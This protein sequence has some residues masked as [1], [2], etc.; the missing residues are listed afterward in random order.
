MIIKSDNTETD[1]LLKHFGIE[2]IN[3]YIANVL[4]VKST[5]INSN[6]KK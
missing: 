5:S 6:N 4:K 1:V 2:N 3:H